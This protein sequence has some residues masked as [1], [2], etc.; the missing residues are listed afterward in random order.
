[1]LTVAAPSLPATFAAQRA[2]ILGMRAGLADQEVYVCETH[3][4]MDSEGIHLHDGVRACS[5][6]CRGSITFEY[7]P[8]EYLNEELHQLGR[9]ELRRIA[10]NM[11]AAARRARRAS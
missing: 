9:G 5:R 4:P 10:E 7:W 2:A 6:S 8:G 1:M 3:G 11:R